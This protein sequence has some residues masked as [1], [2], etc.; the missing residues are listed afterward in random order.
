MTASTANSGSV[1]SHARIASAKPCAIR[2]CA[3][4]AAHAMMN[5]DRRMLGN[6]QIADHAAA[7]AAV[8]AL[9]SFSIIGRQERAF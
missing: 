1:C 7:E 2:N 5:A 8:V 9:M 4:S 6:V 3:A